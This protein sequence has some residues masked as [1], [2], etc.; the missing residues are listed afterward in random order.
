MPREVPRTNLLR[1]RHFWSPPRLF[2]SRLKFLVNFF[3]WSSTVHK[4]GSWDLVSREAECY[5]KGSLYQR[6]FPNSESTV[7]IAITQI[8]RTM[9]FVRDKTES[10]STHQPDGQWDHVTM[11]NSSIITK[12]QPSLTGSESEDE[13][14]DESIAQLPA[15]V[16]AFF[17]NVTR[18]GYPQA[19]SKEPKAQPWKR[20]W[21]PQKAADDG[22][23]L[24]ACPKRC[25]FG[26]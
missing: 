20:M 1:Y 25:D 21:E 3:C 22:S 16:Q 17:A 19:Q 14:T 26:N 2:C 5:R 11:A 8:R 24:V 15:S 13:P 9:Y 6:G 7:D 4:A 10:A 18:D 23:L 12:S